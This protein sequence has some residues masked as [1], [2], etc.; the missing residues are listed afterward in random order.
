MDEALIKSTLY[1]WL[2][3]ELG[4]RQ[5]FTITFDI[6]FV[7]G[8]TCNATFTD[9]EESVPVV[10]TMPAVDF[11]GTQADTMQALAAAIQSLDHIFKASVTAARQITCISQIPGV[12]IAVST[13]QTTGGL[14][15]PAITI[16]ETVEA[17]EVTVIFSDQ[18]SPRPPDYPYAV[19]RLNNAGQIGY[20]EMRALDQNGIATIGGQRRATVYIDYFGPQPFENLMKASNSLEKETNVDFFYAAGIAYLTKNDV[21]NLTAMLETKYEERAS[22]DFYIGYAEN[23]EDDVGLIE[24]AELTGSITS[25]GSDLDVDSVTVGPILIES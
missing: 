21:Q 5:Q 6:D 17:E 9:D 2:K 11:A 25:D 20:D 7:T 16:V 4:V 10:E 15:Q 18:N 1:D 12:P 8:N 24:S 19:I 13:F 3:R 14:T 22:F 23:F